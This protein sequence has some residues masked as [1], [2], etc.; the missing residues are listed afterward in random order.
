MSE[1]F[2]YGNAAGDTTLTLPMSGSDLTF[3]GAYICVDMDDT[4]GLSMFV[5]H[6]PGTVAGSLGEPRTFGFPNVDGLYYARVENHVAPGD[7][8]YR[9][10]QGFHGTTVGEVT[11]TWTDD[12]GS[13]CPLWPA[14]PPP[15]LTATPGIGQ[16]TLNWTSSFSA[17]SHFWS[18]EYEIRRQV[19]GGATEFSYQHDIIS[20][21]DS[22]VADGHTYTY[23]VRGQE[24]VIGGGGFSNPVTVTW[25]PDTGPP[26][27]TG[28]V[29]SWGMIAK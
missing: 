4:A 16:V 7:F 8:V 1:V 11:V 6:P 12:T 29:K 17:D 13:L 15:V 19:D 10:T 26:D 5:E 21:V 27:T 24:P 23:Q 9:V 25:P 2:I 18:I 22:D 20:Y 28:V 14:T 3:C